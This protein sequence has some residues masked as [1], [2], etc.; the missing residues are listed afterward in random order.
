MD[1]TR[2]CAKTRQ[3]EESSLPIDNAPRQIPKFSLAIL[4]EQI[5]IS[6][7]KEVAL[8][9]GDDILGPIPYL[10]NN[11]RLRLVCNVCHIAP[12]YYKQ[13]RKLAQLE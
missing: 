4:E 13:K 6:T 12:T 7:L 3:H 2:R 11:A 10:L 9:M 1:K 8:F 5:T